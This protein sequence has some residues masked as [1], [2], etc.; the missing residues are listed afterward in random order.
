MNNKKAELKSLVITKGIMK[1]KS[2]DP[3]EKE[4]MICR[5]VI[6]FSASDLCAAEFHDLVI[7]R[8]S[9]VVREWHHGG[10][11]YGVPY[12]GTTG[13]RVGGRRQDARLAGRE[14]CIPNV[15]ERE[16]QTEERRER[17]EDR[18][19]S[20]KRSNSHVKKIQMSETERERGEGGGG[21]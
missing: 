18:K 10:S 5:F 16:S 21:I 6:A 11:S 13:R 3:T 12:G 20:A 15:L 17:E 19:W 1:M 2:L 4:K 14:A 8:L 9:L 7:A